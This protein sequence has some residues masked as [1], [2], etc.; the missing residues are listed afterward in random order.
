MLYTHKFLEIRK[1]MLSGCMAQQAQEN[2]GQ[3]NPAQ[4]AVMD[5]GF[6]ASGFSTVLQMPTGAGKTWLA[7]QGIGST[8][9]SGARAVYL[10]PLRALAN[11]LVERWSTRFEGF[12]VGV[13]TGEYG[14]RQ[15]Y[16]IAFE[17]ARLLIMT[18]ERLDACMRNWRSHW[19]W[20]PDVRLL[21]VDELHLLGERGRG[22]RLEGALMRARQ[23]NPFL[24]VLGLSATMG[25][26]AELADWLGGVHFQSSWKP[27]PIQWRCARYRR[28]TDKPDPHR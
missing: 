28:A 5:G 25:N 15:S 8:L 20:F 21:V 16:P 12:E 10:T 1:R 4:R 7:E 13:F 18:P 26:R 6:L 24:Q 17:R 9:Q 23:L 14:K 27:I 3:L 19:C 2:E 11:E 22:P